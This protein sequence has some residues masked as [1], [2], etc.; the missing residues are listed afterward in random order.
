MTVNQ[1]AEQLLEIVENKADENPDKQ[2]MWHVFRAVLHAFSNVFFFLDIFRY[3]PKSLV[4]LCLALF[5]Q[6]IYIQVVMET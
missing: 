5:R 6:D 1:A 2:G 4:N 3:D